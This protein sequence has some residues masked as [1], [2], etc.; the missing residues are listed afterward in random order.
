[1]PGPERI[2]SA[3]AAP[4]DR[5]ERTG[6]RGWSSSPR[7]LPQLRV[8]EVHAEGAEQRELRALGPVE[9]AQPRHVHLEEPQEGTD[10][11]R[12]RTGTLAVPVGLARPPVGVLLDLRPVLL[13]GA[14]RVV[15]ERVLQ[16]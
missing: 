3:P 7:H 4:T 13:P 15:H 14:E 10:E 6:G 1:M 9:E 8:L 5:I 2:A 11:N 12:G 16:G